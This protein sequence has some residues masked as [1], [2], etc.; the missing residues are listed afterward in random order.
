MCNYHMILLVDDNTVLF[1]RNNINDI[2][3]DVWHVIY[4]Y[5][6]YLVIMFNIKTN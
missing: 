2:F 3:E 5:Y 1:T 6:N 4:Y